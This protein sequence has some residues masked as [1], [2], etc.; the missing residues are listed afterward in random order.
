MAKS[1][2]S[3]ILAMALCAGVMAGIYA[4]PVMAM[5]YI[6][7]SNYFVTNG[8]INTGTFIGGTYNGGTFNG[9]LLFHGN[10]N[11]ENL[12]VDG[13]SVN[14]AAAN[15]VYGD[16]LTVGGTTLDFV[17]VNQTISNTSGITSHSDGKVTTI[18][19]A[20]SVNENGYIYNKNGSFKVTR[21]GAIT[22]STYNGVKLAIDGNKVL[23]GDIDVSEMADN[24]EGIV[25]LGET[26]TIEKTVSAA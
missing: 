7:G 2:K 11:M 15:G 1:K 14:A 20:F 9:E 13:V 21:D 8:T 6:D 12:L 18:E 10:A 3:K 23:V 25:R 19:G 17:Q 26:T 4:S 22:A 5:K 24:T 16:R